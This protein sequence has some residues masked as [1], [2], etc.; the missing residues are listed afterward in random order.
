MFFHKFSDIFYCKI[1]EY[2]SFAGII[3]ISGLIFFII[4]KII[5]FEVVKQ[6]FF[7]IQKFTQNSIIRNEDVSWG[8]EVEIVVQH[9]V[10][11]T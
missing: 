6:C 8:V 11:A 7:L 10:E 2:T 9:D 1:F 3:K 5:T 4:Y